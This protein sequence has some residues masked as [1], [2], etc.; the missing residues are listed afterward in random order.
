MTDNI[1]QTGRE[2]RELIV[3]V[4]QKVIS[5]NAVCSNFGDVKKLRKEMQ[6]ID[7]VIAGFTTALFEITQVRKSCE[8]VLAVENKSYDEKIKSLENFYKL[9]TRH[10]MK[11]T[12][13]DM[14]AVNIGDGIIIEVESYNNIK[15]I[16]DMAYGAIRKSITDVMIVF[17]LNDDSFVSCTS[18]FVINDYIACKNF[19]TV[20]CTNEKNCVYGDRCRFFHDPIIWD[21]SKHVQRFARTNMVVCDPYF[22]DGPTFVGNIACDKYS[23]SHLKTLARYCSTMLLLI[24]KTIDTKN[25]I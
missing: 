6:I 22:G 13:R 16:P 10:Y 18:I 3:S 19:R 1:D 9:P 2:L 14:V 15:Q 23:F 25:G 24:K 12:K 5:I 17:K 21:D 7:D 11:Q 8:K 4:K 20:C